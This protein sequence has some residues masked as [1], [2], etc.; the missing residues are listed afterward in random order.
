M[1]KVLELCAVK[2]AISPVE[3][4]RLRDYVP[5]EQQRMLLIEGVE[6]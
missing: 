5:T 4:V 1:Q 2:I 6:V 3:V